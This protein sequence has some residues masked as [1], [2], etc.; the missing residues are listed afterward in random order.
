MR[1]ATP[2]RSRTVKVTVNL[3]EEIV[4]AVRYLAAKRGVSRTEVLRQAISTEK[5]LDDSVSK[6]DSVVLENEESKERRLIV[7]QR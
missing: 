1:T 2:T 4:E 7:F 6:G 5:F 3:P